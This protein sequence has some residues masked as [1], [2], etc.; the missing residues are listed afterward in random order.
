M[1]KTTTQLIQEKIGELPEGTEIKFRALPENYTEITVR[2]KTTKQISPLHY[3]LSNSENTKVYIA[4][5]QLPDIVNVTL[6]K[7]NK[8]TQL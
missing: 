8:L 5:P 4:D 2:N 3:Y 7:Q 6:A 1:S